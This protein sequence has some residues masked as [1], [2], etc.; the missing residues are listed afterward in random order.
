M[1]VC[2]KCRIPKDTQEFHRASKASKT[3]DGLQSW[4][5]SCCSIYQRERA[6]ANPAYKK[7]A[8]IKY[9]YKLEQD[10]YDEAVKKGC[11]L[12]GIKTGVVFAVDHDHSCCPKTPTCGKC[13]RSILCSRCNSLL[14]RG[15]DSIERLEDAIKYLK[16]WKHEHKTKG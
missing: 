13:V 9:A 8:H 16:D 6:F 7:Y 11:G 15:E 5:M 1:K 14:G 12:C 3:K 10:E 4:C 2:R